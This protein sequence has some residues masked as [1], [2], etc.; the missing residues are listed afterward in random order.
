MVSNAEAK[1]RR[2][3][4]STDGLTR[5]RS[6]NSYLS[7]GEWLDIGTPEQYQYAEEAFQLHR[8]RYLRNE[9][10]ELAPPD[11]NTNRPV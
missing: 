9:D 8:A 6:S 1:P 7:C 11:T 5:A 2:E 4:V 10:V 3:G